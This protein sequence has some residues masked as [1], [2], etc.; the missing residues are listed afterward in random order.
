MSEIKAVLFDA[1]GVVVQPGTPFSHQY[2]EAHGFDYSEIT[3]FFHGDFQDA[4]IGKADL[5]DLLEKNREIWKLDGSPDDL[6][7]QW[8]QAE[9][10]VDDMLVEEIKKLRELG[11][12]C[13]LATNQEKYRAKYLEEEM[14]LG[15]FERI[16]SSAMLGVKKP[17]EEFYAKILEELAADEIQPEQIV[18]F[19]DDTENVEAAQRLGIRAVLYRDI[20]DFKNVFR[21]EAD[22]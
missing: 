9:H 3:P 7:A 4:L 16:Y 22:L 8:F 18:Y 12:H 10:A 6:M 14:F 11:V 21:E 20:D 15:V 19:D 13:F 5:K 17:S 1:D 2:A